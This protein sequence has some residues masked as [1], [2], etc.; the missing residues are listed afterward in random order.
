M[1]RNKT[2]TR[3]NT[4]PSPIKAADILDSNVNPILI[5]ENT[6]VLW[7]DKGLHNLKKNDALQILDS[8]NLVTK[9]CMI[10]CTY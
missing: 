3:V 4:Y 6:R 10:L 8:K 2:N 1:K 5:N 9:T 7:S